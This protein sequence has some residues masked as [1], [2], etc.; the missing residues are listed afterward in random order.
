MGHPPYK[1]WYR[2]WLWGN[3]I[4][5][6]PNWHNFEIVLS[7][8]I[9]NVRNSEVL[10]SKEVNLHRDKGWSYLFNT[11]GTEI[12]FSHFF[13]SP[14]RLYYNVFQSY[15]FS[16]TTLSWS[17]FHPYL[18]NFVSPD[19]IHTLACVAFCWHM[20]NSPGAMPLKKIWL[21]LYSSYQLSIVT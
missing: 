19:A 2:Q 3:D 20:V 4:I 6:I 13:I 7:K 16:S 14:L 9:K 21:L 10:G 11:I 15:L 18:P 5:T 12:S 8:I 1:N 17:I